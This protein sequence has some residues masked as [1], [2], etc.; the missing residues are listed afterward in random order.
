MKKAQFTIVVAGAGVPYE[1]IAGPF[2][3]TADLEAY[4]HDHRYWDGRYISDH[5]ESG[6]FKVELVK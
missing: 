4:A 3:Q 6:D 5:I 1:V 2:S